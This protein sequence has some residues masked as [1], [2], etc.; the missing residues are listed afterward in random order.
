MIPQMKIRFG[1]HLSAKVEADPAYRTTTYAISA[2]L[3]FANFVYISGM[4][5]G[6]GMLRHGFTPDVFA[7]IQGGDSMQES[8]LEAF[9]KCERVDVLCDL[10]GYE[11]IE[12]A[13]NL[14]G[15]DHYS[16]FRIN[17]IFTN[18]GSGD[19]VGC[20]FGEQLSW[21]LAIA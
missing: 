14:V 6:V 3:K 2:A 7:D 4:E 15:R 5:D 10:R 12:V 18:D 21:H 19:I 8:F 1:E 11:N 17:A 20:A 16:K 13:V 9:K